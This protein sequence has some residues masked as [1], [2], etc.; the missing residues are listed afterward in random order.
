MSSLL[1]ACWQHMSKHITSMDCCRVDHTSFLR[2]LH[3]ADSS[4]TVFFTA[5]HC[6]QRGIGDRKAVRRLSVRPS[7]AWI[8]TKRKHSERSLMMNRKSTMDF[9]MS[10]RRTLYV[11]LYGGL[12]LLQAAPMIS[13]FRAERTL[14]VTTGG[15][16]TLPSCVRKPTSLTIWVYIRAPHV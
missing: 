2:C 12:H 5:L 9:P 15:L 13:I 1:N 16:L 8:V 7:N 3:S 10:L 4:M 6:M 11:G 14:Q